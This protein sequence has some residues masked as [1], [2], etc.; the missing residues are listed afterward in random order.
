MKG[1]HPM[2]SHLR[3][4]SAP[5]SGFTLLELVSTTALLGLVVASMLGLF[6]GLQRTAARETSRSQTTDLVRVAIDRMTKDIRQA[7]AIDPSSSASVLDMQT[8]VAG[9][10]RNVV[11][12]ASGADLLTRTTDGTTVTLLERMTLTAVFAYSPDV[13]DPSVITISVIAKPEKFSKD[14]AEISLSSE[15]KLRNR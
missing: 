8:F 13:T 5:E 14:V 10:E 12:D 9:V 4:I 6:A 11:Y 7:T 1:R 3:R 15:V 2:R